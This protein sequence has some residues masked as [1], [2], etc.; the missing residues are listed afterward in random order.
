V[1]GARD[2]RREHRLDDQRRRH[3]DPGEA[4][5]GAN[6]QGCQAAREQ[7]A[8]RHQRESDDELARQR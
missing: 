1:L 4:R 6:S 5:T 2:L 8:E 7:R 3:R